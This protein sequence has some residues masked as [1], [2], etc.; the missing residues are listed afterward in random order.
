MHLK[1]RQLDTQETPLMSIEAEE[2]LD[3]YSKQRVQLKDFILVTRA[4]GVDV[5][6]S[7]IINTARQQA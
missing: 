4:T 3:I 6:I 1:E 2:S 7:R 5:P